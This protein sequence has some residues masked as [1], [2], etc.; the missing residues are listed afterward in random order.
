MLKK[1]LALAFFLFATPALAQNPQCPTRPAGD[2][3]NACASTAFVQSAVTPVRGA[4]VSCS[5]QGV[6]NTLTASA[7][8]SA[9]S[10]VLTFTSVPANVRI[11]MTAF[12]ASDSLSFNRGSYV[13]AKTATQ[14]TISNNTGGVAVGNSINFYG[15][16][17][18]DPTGVE[19]DFTGTTTGGLQEA[20]TASIPNGYPLIYS[21][22]YP[23]SSDDTIGDAAIGGTSTVT[24]PPSLFAYFDMSRGCQVYLN[25][26]NGF[27]FDSTSL[28]L[29]WFPQILRN[30]GAGSALLLRPI[31][32]N[33]VE[34]GRFI[35]DTKFF[36]NAL[37]TT[38][39]SAP[40]LATGRNIT[41]NLAGNGVNA[42]TIAKNDF[43]IQELYGTGGSGSVA[44]LFVVEN[45]TATSQFTG[46][47][48]DVQQAHGFTAHAFNNGVTTTQQASLYQNS[49]KVRKISPAAGATTANGFKQYG[50]Y[51]TFE[52]GVDNDE[53]SGGNYATAATFQSGA[54]GNTGVIN[55][56]G[57]SATPAITYSSAPGN[58]I[59][60]NGT[61]AFIAAT[62]TPAIYL[63]QSNSTGIPTSM[64][65]LDPEAAGGNLDFLRESTRVARLSTTGS[66]TVG[67]PGT[68]TG[69]NCLL[70]LTSGTACITTQAIAGSPVAT[71]GTGTGT[72]VVTATA[73]LGINVATGDVS[74]GTC[75]TT[76]GANIPSVAQ[77]DLL[78]GSASQVLSA[79]A[80]D[81]NATRYLSNTGGSNNPAWA[82][83]NL[84]NGVTGDLPFA[85]LTQGATNTV[86]ANATSGTADFAAFA[87]G[88]CSTAGSA[89]NW[90]TNTGFGCNTSITAAAVPV[91]GITGLG[92]DVATWLAT[93]SSANLAT[94]VT[95]ETGTGAL[96]FGTDP[97]VTTRFR[98]ATG[99]TNSVRIAQDSGNTTYSV[100][101]FNDVDT[102]AA[103]IGIRGGGSG[104]PNLRF[105]VPTGGTLMVMVNGAQNPGVNCPAGISAVT[106]RSVAGLI[107]AC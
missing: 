91:G 23:R 98:V 79:L 105:A 76:A 77:G 21:C 33:P 94:A 61:S 9:G 17:C 63:G 107:T 46:N 92:A 1:L 19:I 80:K 22:R 51:D 53:M 68:A 45:Q 43:Y 85:N 96:M 65:G 42:V 40:G 60:S 29:F 25:A 14:V 24:F 10:P 64:W 59:R 83:I 103:C 73:P 66:W 71:L 54:I 86:L 100:L 74:C 62:S 44:E 57:N 97:V 36:I 20:V 39:T 6:I 56:T 12:N 50:R 31:N 84:A 58:N 81:T 13:I 75:A 30:Y 106:G 48:I 89:L 82:Q 88:S 26:T 78:Y 35:V 41:A 47:L 101:C 52:L 15:Y 102:T 34:G 16:K 70:G 5:F 7:I 99:A 90:T 49:W 4:G 93:P 55:Y 87:M 72:I 3:T 11:G 69:Q 38:P 28:G 8:T 37:V 104:D 32:P 67:V 2:S 27:Q 18:Y 95:G